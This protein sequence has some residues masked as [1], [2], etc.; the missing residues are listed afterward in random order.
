MVARRA[1]N[2]EVVGSSPASATTKD[3]SQGLSFFS[4]S[5]LG[6]RIW[7]SEEF[8]CGQFDDFVRS[9]TV[10]LIIEGYKEGMC[11]Q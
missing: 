7:H 8:E 3:K 6:M 11:G 2:P 10:L 4:L 1:H 5:T 9:A